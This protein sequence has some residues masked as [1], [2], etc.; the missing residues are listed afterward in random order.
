M[1]FL[2]T[3]N[4]S[5][6]KYTGRIKEAPIILFTV[7]VYVIFS[8]LAPNFNNLKNVS[9][10]LEQITINGIAAI[11]MTIV[12]M[13]GGMDLSVGSILALCGVTAG[14]LDNQNIPLPVVILVTLIVGVLA[15]T[16]N[17]LIITRLKIP[18]IIVTLAMMNIYRGLAVILSESKW[19]TDF[20]SSFKAIGSS[21]NGLLSIPVLTLAVVIAVM[22]FV[23]KKTPYGR[24]FYAVG[25]NQEAAKIMGL[26]V[27]KVRILVYAIN[28]LLLAISGILFAS[29]YGS[30][31]ASKTA[32]MLQFETMGSALIGGAN[33]FGGSGTV[34]GT[35]FGVFLLGI[36]KNGLIQVHASEYWLDF[37]TGAIILLALV[38]NLIKIRK[39]GA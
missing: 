17:G 36:M 25:G 7:L 32:L 4:S 3:K 30:I 38:V 23:L 14:M 26:N 8:V 15:G 11:G 21:K 27:N 22:I 24:L 9:V 34:I 35:V 6:L 2:K 33:I 18:D 29:M 5:V 28:G 37:I 19:I 13:I 39:K 20:S 10:I 12:I 1:R 16:I 31:Q